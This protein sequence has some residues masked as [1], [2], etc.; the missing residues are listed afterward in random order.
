MTRF[1]ALQY[2]NTE[3][4]EAD[5]ESEVET[6][7]LGW[8]MRENGAFKHKTIGEATQSPFRICIV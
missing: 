8:K 6:P 7:L 2:E 5:F 1:A 3:G 4:N